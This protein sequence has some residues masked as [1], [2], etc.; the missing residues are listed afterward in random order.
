M[1]TAAQIGLTL[2]MVVGTLRADTLALVAA[3]SATA[4]AAAQQALL[5]TGK[6]TAVTVIDT[7]TSTPDLA[8]LGGFTNV[9]V[10]T[11]AAPFDRVAL[12]DVLANFYD[13]GGKHLTIATYGFS[14]ILPV[15]PF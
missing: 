8:A 13:L 3:D 4:E 9:L 7:Q 5:A 15:A 2:A 14:N 11:S 1:K 6:F 10:W 12:G